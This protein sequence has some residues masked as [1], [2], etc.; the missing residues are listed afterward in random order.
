M[1]RGRT[2]SRP[3]SKQWHCLLL[4]A[5]LALPMS[6]MHRPHRRATA[7]EVPA[8]IAGAGGREAAAHDDRAVLRRVEPVAQR[9]AHPWAHAP[10]VLED[11]PKRAVAT[12]GVN[13]RRV[14][15]IAA[16]HH[17]A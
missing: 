13:A 16:V 6:E 12:A 3:K 8:R 1:G 17:L 7:V 9:G 2:G 15:E 11:L 10:V 14:A 5:Y 4:A